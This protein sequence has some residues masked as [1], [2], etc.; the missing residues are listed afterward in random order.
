MI[1][2]GIIGCGLI[3]RKRANSL[4]PNQ[5]IAVNDL[6]LNLSR[7]FAEEF[8]VK[9]CQNF[10]ELI[11]IKE[12]DLVIVSTPHNVL[13]SIGIKCILAGKHILIEKPAGISVSDLKQLKEESLK[14]NRKIH[15]GFNHRFHP[16][17]L[18]SKEIIDSGLLGQLMYIRGR[19][20]HG[21]RVGYE[22]EWRAQKTISGGGELIDQGSH[23]ID[24]SRWF[25]GDFEKISGKAKTFFWDMD[26]EDNGFMILETKK[27]Q[28]AFLHA[29]CTEWKNLFS[30]EIF[31][32]LGK[33]HVNGLGGSYGQEQ[34]TFYKMLPEMG[35]PLEENWSFEE[36]TSWVDEVNDFISIIANDGS[37]SSSIDDAIANLQIIQ[38]IYKDSNYDYYT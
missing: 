10:E 28:T 19:Y 38:K 35:P 2:V 29:S 8:G 27:S 32:K 5:L 25:L 17:F 11:S 21:G 36:D 6:D 12:I 9:H 34:L 4:A 26:V 16:A 18:K 13:T 15:V 22:K 24:L 7:S 20:G 1:K 23:L 14:L 37:P 31:G 30:F 3:G 33:L